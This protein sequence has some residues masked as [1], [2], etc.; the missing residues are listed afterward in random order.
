M[1]KKTCR[2]VFYK[3]SALKQ[4]MTEEEIKK[5]IICVPDKLN[6]DMFYKL[7]YS[8]NNKF[9]F[10]GY[11]KLMKRCYTQL[12]QDIG[13]DIKLPECNY[14]SASSINPDL[15]LIK[16]YL[17]S[18]NN[19]KFSSELLKQSTLQ[20]LER[21][22]DSD[23][24][25]EIWKDKKYIEELQTKF[26]SNKSTIHIVTH[27]FKF[28]N[29]LIDYTDITLEKLD[30]MFKGGHTIIAGD[31]GIIYN[32]LFTMSETELQAEEAKLADKFDHSKVKNAIAYTYAYYNAEKNS[33]KKSTK[34]LNRTYGLSS[35]KSYDYTQLRIGAGNIVNCNETIKSCISNRFELLVGTSTEKGYEGDTWFQFERSRM[36]NDTSKFYHYWDFVMYGATVVGEYFKISKKQNLG[37]FGWSDYNDTN[38]QYISIC[39]T[40]KNRKNGQLEHCIHKTKKS[41]EVVNLSLE[42][43][44]HIDYLDENRH[45]GYLGPFN[46]F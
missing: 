22:K 6:R 24:T 11:N 10:I 14:M 4:K 23:P 33:E 20:E 29:D 32:K 35:H 26:E 16:I 21:L 42:K 12:G 17:A 46:D 15:H 39:N 9:Y 41:T 25:N 3:D 30:Q 38:P 1:S 45:D 43:Q 8:G 37:P 27:I 31:K 36:D 5:D 28:I 2:G 44:A 7:D 18:L 13:K 34:I 40:V 19:E